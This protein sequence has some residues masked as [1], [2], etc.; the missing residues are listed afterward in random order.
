M[1]PS[2]R[3]CELTS[4]ATPR[5]WNYLISFR[6][7]SKSPLW[8]SFATKNTHT[9]KL[10]CKYFITEVSLSCET[11][12]VAA[13]VSL[14]VRPLTI[15]PSTTTSIVQRRQRYVW[16]SKNSHTSGRSIIYRCSTESPCICRYVLINSPG[17]YA[18][19]PTRC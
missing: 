9:Q 6:Q 8:Y 5:C 18:S 13:W 2:L 17:N 1:C 15:H 19:P 14:G 16:D 4:K 11:A 10:N 7:K 3:N 12:A